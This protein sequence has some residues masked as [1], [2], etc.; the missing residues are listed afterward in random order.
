MTNHE[1]IKEQN[2]FG[3]GEKLLCGKSVREEVR[4]EMEMN[5]ENAWKD[6]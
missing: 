5:G 2:T 1:G 6:I 3:K 4:M